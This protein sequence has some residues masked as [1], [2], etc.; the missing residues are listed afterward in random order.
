MKAGLLFVLTMFI[1]SVSAEPINRKGPD[2]GSDARIEIVLLEDFK[3]NAPAKLVW[4]YFLGEKKSK[5]TL[6]Y[7]TIA[8]QAD[9]LGEIYI[10]SAADGT[11]NYPTSSF[12]IIKIEEARHLVLTMWDHASEDAPRKLVGYDILNLFQEEGGTKVLF[13][14]VSFI[15]RADIKKVFSVKS[16]EVNALLE[17]FDGDEIK[18]YRHLRQAF[19]SDIFSK[20]KVMIEDDSESQ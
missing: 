6:P 10:I 19:F 1:T 7:V 2:V 4:S 15:D 16:D 17:K 9:E 5:W 12:E 8:G 13:N 11:I 18:A 14:Q 20:L 3:V